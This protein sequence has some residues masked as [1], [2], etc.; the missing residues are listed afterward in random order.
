[1]RILHVIPQY[2]YYHRGKVVGGHAATLATLAEAQV[3]LGH[4]PCVM[5]RVP[6]DLRVT[7]VEVS[8]VGDV[9]TAG[10][11]LPTLWALVRIT[12][13]AATRFR[14]ADIVHVHSGYAEYAA[15]SAVL[16]IATRRPVVHSIYCPVPERRWRR[17]ASSIALR[18]AAILGVRFAGF[19]QNIADQIESATH[20]PTA[21]VGP[22]IDIERFRPAEHTRKQGQ[23][24]VVFVGNTSAE[25]NL[26]CVLRA[27]A[28]AK[29]RGVD[30]LLRVTLELDR[31][32]PDERVTELR[33]LTKTLG[34]EQTIEYYR[35]V[36]DM[37]ALL[38]SS[39]VSVAPFLHTD[40]P[41]DYF[42]TSL[43]SMAT[44]LWVIASDLPAMREVLTPGTGFLVDPANPAALAE[45]FEHLALDPPM[46]IRRA[47]R[48]RAETHF[49][50]V[51]AAQRLHDSLYEG[52][53]Q[54]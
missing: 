46:E 32:S 15:W 7:D 38:G 17:L 19:S 41:S 47:A 39:D 53:T 48:E 27:G 14:D 10:R 23:L 31:T 13:R 16:R 29:E 25:K 54:K 18:F 49:S 51:D 4:R 26:E 8:S 40:G 11:Y 42:L 50:S 37:P 44:G 1:M 43:E 36:D 30:I 21:A 3:E 9:A 34:L 52:A 35:I 20:R 28:L 22:V 33:E 24:R 45:L 5:S 12:A 2:P 6:A